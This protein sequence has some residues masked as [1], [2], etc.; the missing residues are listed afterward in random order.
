MDQN[1]TIGNQGTL[2]A[3]GGID[4]DH[5]PDIKITASD[6]KTADAATH[7]SIQ[8]MA[9]RN[10]AFKPLPFSKKEIH[11]IAPYLSSPKIIAPTF[12]ENMSPI[13]ANN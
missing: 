12:A 7:K 8:R 2:V 3:M 5:F 4:F 1:K 13:I 11:Q 6:Q 10:E 9:K